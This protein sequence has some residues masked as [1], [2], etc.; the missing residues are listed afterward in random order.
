MK[1]T[2]LIGLHIF[3]IIFRYANHGCFVGT[4]LHENQDGS[5]QVNN[6]CSSFVVQSPI[7]D[8]Q[9][10]FNAGPDTYDLAVC[11][12]FCNEGLC[13]KE[14]NRPELDDSNYQ[15][16]GSKL[17]INTV[18]CHLENFYSKFLF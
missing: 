7:C 9:Y 17:S 11:K 10:D 15:R 3:Q 8:I 12:E 16:K 5:H 6:G 2:K 13:N 14:H 4:N 1:L 18:K